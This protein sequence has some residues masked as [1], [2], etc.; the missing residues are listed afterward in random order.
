MKNYIKLQFQN[1]KFI[2]RKE[3]RF[4]KAKEKTDFIPVHAAPET[5][6]NHEF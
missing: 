3:L 1:L 2:R 6:Q 4:A 5:T